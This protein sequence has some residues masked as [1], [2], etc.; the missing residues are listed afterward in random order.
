MTELHHLIDTF[1]QRTSFKFNEVHKL[2]P[3]IKYG[4]RSDVLVR[5]FYSILFIINRKI[6][7]IFADAAVILKLIKRSSFKFSIEK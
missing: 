4:F 5:L 3:T 6:V 2:S 7:F 1:S